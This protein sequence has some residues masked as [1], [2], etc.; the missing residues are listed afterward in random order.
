MDDLGGHRDTRSAGP[1]CLTKPGRMNSE[2]VRWYHRIGPGLITACVVI[3]PGSIL[4]SSRV[5][6]TNGFSMSWVVLV[7][8]AFMLVYT[9]L[10]AKLGVVAENSPGELI[11][12]NV[13]RWLAVLI[14]A[15]VFFISAAFQFG[16][17]LGVLAAFQEFDSQLKRIPYFELDYVLIFFNLMSISFLFGFRNL[18]RA[19]ERLMMVLVGL[20]LLSFAVNLIFARPPLG[21]LLAGFVPPLDIFSGGPT[22]QEESSLDI[23]LLALVGTTFVITAAFFQAYLVRQKGWTKEQ[24]QDGMVDA[25]VGAILM[26]SITIMIMSTAAAELRDRDLQSVAD[27][28]Q[29]LKPAFGNLG[30]LLFCLGLFAA[31][32]SS[33]LINSMIGGFIVSDGL[34]LG[35]RPTDLWPRI[36]TVVVLMTGMTIALLVHRAGLNAVPAIVAAQAVTVV[37]AP[38]VAIALWWLTN[39]REIMG[40]DRN[41]WPTNLCALGGLLM[42]LAMAWYTAVHKVAPQIQAWLQPATG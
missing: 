24:M 38:L 18:Y 34:G 20:M 4:T 37:A 15:G 7:A 12:R 28:A 8:V 5:G 26:A 32:Y 16:N 9:S 6:A 13:G 36:M 14:G 10:G 35:S 11:A 3:G 1:N 21:E 29:G 17:N 23:S 40:D 33:F 25:R 19:V 41:S 22:S 31:A 30:H 42:L 2:H 27:V 39:Q